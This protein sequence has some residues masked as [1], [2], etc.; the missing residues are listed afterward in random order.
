LYPS[1]RLYE[2]TPI[3]VAMGLATNSLY[4]GSAMYIESIADQSSLPPPS[5]LSIGV[6]GVVLG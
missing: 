2:R 1:S 5:S 4:G 6:E 3:G